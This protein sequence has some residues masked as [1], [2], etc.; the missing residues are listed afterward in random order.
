MSFFTFIF[1]MSWI[2]C[3]VASACIA[4]NKGRD[5]FSRLLGTM[6]IGPVGILIWLLPERY[7]Q[8]LG[9]PPRAAFVCGIITFCMSLGGLYAMHIGEWGNAAI[10][11]TATGLMAQMVFLDNEFNPPKPGDDNDDSQPPPPSKDAPPR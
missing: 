8:P 5:W 4:A 11:M 10:L 2:G 7:R 1:F 6:M 9:L 3:S